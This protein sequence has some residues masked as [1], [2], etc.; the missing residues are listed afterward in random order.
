M[1]AHLNSNQ[2]IQ[3]VVPSRAAES[4]K[5]RR[6][7]WLIAGNYREC[8][9][10]ARKVRSLCSDLEVEQSNSRVWCSVA[11]IVSMHTANP[12][13][14]FLSRIGVSLVKCPHF[15]SAEIVIEPKTF[16]ERQNQ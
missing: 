14:M 3:K 11:E 1:L 4:S 10:S 16:T 2:V 13:Q 12:L 8:C 15:C 9:C 5:V 6:L 7:C